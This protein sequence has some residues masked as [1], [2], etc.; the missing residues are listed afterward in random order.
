MQSR[1]EQQVLDTFVGSAIQAIQCVR[2]LKMYEELLQE[3]RR[4][5]SDASEEDIANVVAACQGVKE[6]IDRRLPPELVVVCVSSQ[7]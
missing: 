3:M 7:R 5:G 6:Q 4:E 1:A 2:Q